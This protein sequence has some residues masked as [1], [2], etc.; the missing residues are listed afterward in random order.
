[1][2]YYWPKW[3][4]HSTGLTHQPWGSSFFSYPPVQALSIFPPFSL[5]SKRNEKWLANLFKGF[6]ATAVESSA[7]CPGTFPNNQGTRRR[8]WLATLLHWQSKDAFRLLSSEEMV[9]RARLAITRVVHEYTMIVI[10]NTEHQKSERK[11]FNEKK[12]E[13]KTQER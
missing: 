7:G 11:H 5:Q 6:R 8:G 13:E 9:T 4:D 10:W 2:E 1:M 12:A 3:L